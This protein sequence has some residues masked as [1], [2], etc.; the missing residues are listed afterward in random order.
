MGNVPVS[1]SDAGGLPDCGIINSHDTQAPELHC[2]DLLNGQGNFR[3]GAWLT[4]DAKGG[5][6]LT[7]TDS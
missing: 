3:L 1:L 2:G 4:A 5:S 7:F 6:Q